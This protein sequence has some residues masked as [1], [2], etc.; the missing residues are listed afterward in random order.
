MPNTFE[1]DYRKF[2]DVLK[3]LKAEGKIS[4]APPPSDKDASRKYIEN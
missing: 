4:D 3:R 1:D 2:N